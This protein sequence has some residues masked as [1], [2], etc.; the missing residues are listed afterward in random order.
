MSKSQRS[1]D[2]GNNSLIKSHAS[3]KASPAVGPGSHSNF[4]FNKKDEQNITET[5]AYVQVFKQT[6][7][8]YSKLNKYYESEKLKEKLKIRGSLY[9]V[10]STAYSQ[11]KE[12]E[13]LIN[14]MPPMITKPNSLIGIGELDTKFKVF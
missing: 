7:N 4:K 9:G 11:E 3:T 10:P 2:N 14:K 6:F 5:Q 13:E 1:P 8:E 12:I